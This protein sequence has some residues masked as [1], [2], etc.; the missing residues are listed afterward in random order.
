M[1]ITTQALLSAARHK[2]D[3]GEMKGDHGNRLVIAW[4]AIKNVEAMH[5][6]YEDHVRDMAQEALEAV[7]YETPDYDLE[8]LADEIVNVLKPVVKANRI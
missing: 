1:S 6:A 7:G 3:L 8:A 5:Q 2:A 4:H